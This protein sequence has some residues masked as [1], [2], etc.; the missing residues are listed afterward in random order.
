MQA[1]VAISILAVLTVTLFTMAAVHNNDLFWGDRAIL[2]AF[3][4]DD[5]AW[6]RFFALFDTRS[7]VSLAF[8]LPVS[9][10]LWL[11]RKK[12][13]A[14][15]YLLILPTL[16]FTVS[17]PKIFVKRLRPEG[18][19]EGLTN[20]FPSGTATVAILVL[21]FSIFLVG[22]LVAPRGLRI[23]IQIALGIVI[24][25]LGAFRLLAGEHWPSDIVGGYMAGALALWVVIWAYRRVR[26]GQTPA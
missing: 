9:A 14:A 16:V 21:G 7:T 4:V 18:T 26:K 8:V 3:R 23:G 19:L 5:P 25:L 24:V 1:K 13:E 11:L 12:L 17:F 2:S 6:Q 15:A 22:E 10:A 20:S